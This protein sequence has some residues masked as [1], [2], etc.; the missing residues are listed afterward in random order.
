MWKEGRRETRKRRRRKR[1]E[2]WERKGGE[3]ET[4]GRER[5]GNEYRRLQMEVNRKKET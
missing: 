1:E 2:E 3:K 5:G 4:D